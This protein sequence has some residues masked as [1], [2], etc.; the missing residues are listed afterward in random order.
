GTPFGEALSY[1]FHESQSRLWENQ[2]ARR[3]SF[4]HHFYPILQEMFKERLG[5][6]DREGFYKM[7]NTVTPSLIRVEADEVTYSLHIMIRFEIEKMLIDGNLSVNDLP[8]VWDQKMDDYLG[9]RPKDYKDGVMQ[10]I[11]WSMGLFGYFPT[12]ALG[13][14]YAVPIMNQAYVDIPDLENKIQN[15]DLVPL[16]DWLKENIHSKGRRFPAEDLIFQLTGT[17][18][19]AEPYMDYLEKKYGDIYDLK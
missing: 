6:M 18:L 8:E 17:K 9:I 4:W 2:V 11:H 19:T 1:G 10:D 16:R 5:S 14:L 12:Y 7:V 15:A 13:N 3:R